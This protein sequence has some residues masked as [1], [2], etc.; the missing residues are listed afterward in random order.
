MFVDRAVRDAELAFLNAPFEADGWIKALRQLAATTGSNIGQLVGGGPGLALSF[1][2]LSDDCHDPRGHI[3]NPL[4]YGPENWRINCAGPARSIQHERH[5]A[6]YRSANR[7][8]LYDD[9]VSD[10]DLPFGC[11]SP[12]IL[13]AN[14]SLVG[15]ALLRSS[16]DGPCS[17]DTVNTFARVAR[18]AHRAVR[19]EMALG[20]SRGE[21]MLAGLAGSSEMTL[22]LDRHGRLVAMSEAA[23]SLFDL[24]QGLRLQGLFVHLASHAEDRDLRSAMK[25]LTGNQEVDGPVLHQCFV[26]ASEQRPDGCWQLFL[27]R[28]PADRD[29]LGV[30]AQLALTLRPRSHA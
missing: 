5:Y 18:Q 28:L 6:A 16:R 29:V 26:G 2:L 15:L 21:D 14:G 12:L 22:L 7:T 23:E 11:Q 3:H 10:L 20:Q 25:R 4:V 13:E 24:P 8:A 1:N 9:A 30:E 19:V 27:T 17:T